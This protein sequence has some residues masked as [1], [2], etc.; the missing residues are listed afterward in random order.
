[1][2]RDTDTP[3][4]RGGRG[5]A[6]RKMF[7]FP[8]TPCTHSPSHKATPVVKVAGAEKAVGSEEPVSHTRT[9]QVMREEGGRGGKVEGSGVTKE[10]ELEDTMVEDQ[11]MPG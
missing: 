6:A 9:L 5:S 1:M 4:E 3:E 11:F 2:A 8:P 10:V 7:S